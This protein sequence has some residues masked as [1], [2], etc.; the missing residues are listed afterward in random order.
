VVT[1]GKGTATGN[2]TIPTP[3]HQQFNPVDPAGSVT[4]I[5]PAPIQGFPLYK[6]GDHVTFAWNYTNLQ[7]N[8]TAVDVLVSCS[9]ASNT[10]TVTT[11]MTFET[12]G[13]VT[14]DTGGYQATA[15][16]DPLLSDQYTLLIFDAESSVSATAEA[17]YLAPYSG[18]T[19]GMYFPKKYTPLADGW[20]CATCS[21]AVSDMERR[22][23]GVVVVMAVVTTLSFT[24]FVTG[25]GV[26][27]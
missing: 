17:G 15:V 13:H 14:W 11:N 1:G 24:W 27:L 8:P 7:A 10:W 20:T 18:L 6:I 3:T 25:F 9:S 19:F 12:T 22:A 21:G 16:Q 2:G 5:T 26:F 23:L 4:M